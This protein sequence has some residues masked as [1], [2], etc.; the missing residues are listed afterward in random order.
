MNIF[1]FSRLQAAIIN[2]QVQFD[3][4]IYM[5]IYMLIQDNLTCFILGK[6]KFHRLVN[7]FMA[8]IVS[9]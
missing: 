3:L 5:L 6:K 7:F 2:T 1:F 9:S 4:Y 8:I